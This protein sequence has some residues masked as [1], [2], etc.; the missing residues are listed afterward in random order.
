MLGKEYLCQESYLYDFKVIQISWDLIGGQNE[1]T[2]DGIE[3]L[4]IIKL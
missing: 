3:A 4:D 1:L 2:F